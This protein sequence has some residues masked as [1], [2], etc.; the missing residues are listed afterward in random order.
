MTT[1]LMTIQREPSWAKRGTRPR[2]AAVEGRIPTTSVRKL[3]NA[4]TSFEV[5]T[6]VV[7]RGTLSSIPTE[8][9]NAILLLKT[10]VP[11]TSRHIYLNGVGGGH[12]LGVSVTLARQRLETLK[13]ARR[14]ATKMATA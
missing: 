7:S 9:R 13:L 1:P 14:S 3:I 10:K 6:E 2:G 4:K 5:G 12:W 11:P 8:Q